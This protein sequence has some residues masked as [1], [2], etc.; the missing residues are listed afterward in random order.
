MR[1]L[2]PLMLCLAA[3]GRAPVNTLTP[4]PS[5][6]VTVAPL[7][8]RLD[9]TLSSSQRFRFRDRELFT[10]TTSVVGND[11]VTEIRDRAGTVVT[12]ADAQADIRADFGR[13]LTIIAEPGLCETDGPVA[14]LAAVDPFTCTVW[15]RLEQI[16]VN[17]DFFENAAGRGFVVKTQF[18]GNFKL[19][20]IESGHDAATDTDF[21]RFQYEPASAICANEGEACT[22]TA[23]CCNPRHTC[24]GV[25]EY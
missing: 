19:W 18:D 14:S 6:A 16:H 9:T 12:S 7:T 11:V 2:F 8:F 1:S 24:K 15:Q 3:C 23:Q 22:S 5:A 4:E 21:V 10:S 13:Y 17:S 20:V 25:C